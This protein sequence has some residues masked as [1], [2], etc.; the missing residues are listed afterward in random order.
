MSTTTVP[1]LGELTGLLE[2]LRGDGARLSDADRIDRITAL[3]ALKGAAAA[4]QARLTVA[5]DVSQRREQAALGVPA[6]KQGLGVHHQVALARRDSPHKGSR[7]LGLARALVRE[8][9][10]TLGA[11]SAGEISEWRATILVRE[12]ATL[13][14][15]HRAEVDRRLAGRLAGLGDAGV[16]R[17]ARKL[18]Y[19]LDP[20]SVVRRMRRATSERR[21]SVRPA[22]DTMSYVTGLLPVAQGVAVHGALTRH[23]EAL[24]AA[25]D[26]RSR[27]QIMA[28][29]FVQRLTGQAQAPAV[30]VEIQVVM[31]DRTLF[32]DDD[33][34]GRIVGHGPIPAALAR[35]LAGLSASP[36]T[37]A[38]RD[39]GPDAGLAADAA[40][41]AQAA[42]WLRRLYRNPV[43]GDL[44]A[45]DSRR[46]EFPQGLCRFFRIRD[47]I[48]RTPWCDAP[49]RHADH[50]V[51]AADGGETSAANGQGL[52]EACNQAKEAPGWEAWTPPR[53]RAGPVT[54]RTP[55]GHRYTS[56]PPDPPGRRPAWADLRTTLDDRGSPL[57][58]RLTRAHA[59]V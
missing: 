59:P 58:D 39:A 37:D 23:A 14:T 56:R 8:M 42:V 44:V 19:E 31:T 9:P 6:E 20:G 35:A 51:R 50:V 7:H 41:A 54:R 5:F 11:L 24:R 36:G 15:V 30:P 27:G 43:T 32:G 1:T 4:A 13:S 57:E 53:Q 17:E 33:S 34:P 52:C 2:R 28:D 40:Q 29:T 48:C 18:A 49:I 10:H 26:P 46:R 45:M 22:P 3:E 47:E 12:T 55:T 21:V 16:Q 38:G 25:G